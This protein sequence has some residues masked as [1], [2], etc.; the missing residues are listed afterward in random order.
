MLK[1]ILTDACFRIAICDEEDSYH[2][3]VKAILSEIKSQRLLLPW[4]ILYEILRTK[5]VKNPKLVNNFREFIYDIQIEYIEDLPYKD[6]ALK[7]L[8]SY[9]RHLDKKSLVDLV[10]REMLIDKRLRKNNFVTFDISDFRDV[11][12]DMQ[13]EILD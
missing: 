8:L 9:K 12:F 10:L 1:R 13:I 11:C 2:P 4:P 3:N 6:L 7:K 5:F